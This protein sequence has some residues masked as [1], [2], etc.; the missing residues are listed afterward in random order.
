MS[1]DPPDRLADTGPA[2]RQLTTETVYQTNWMQVREDTFERPDGTVA[3]YGVVDRDD[4][5]LV[6]AEVGGAFYLVEQYRYA[7]RR[8]SWEFPAG[9][10]PDG[11]SGTDEELARQELLEETGVT[12]Q[13]L[14]RLGHRMTEASGFCSQGFTVFHATGLTVGEHQRE[15]SEADMV[16]ALIDEQEF[17]AMIADGRIFDAPTI[18]AYALLRL[19]G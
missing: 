2:P 1:F 15:D 17:R 11:H 13:H 8:R 12:A 6:I 14:R 7:L 16:S 18:A 19:L 10:W 4:F 3:T 9:T 5:A